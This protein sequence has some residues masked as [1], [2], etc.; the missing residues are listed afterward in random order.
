MILHVRR[1]YQEGK[2][3]EDKP[4][5]LFFRLEVSPEEAEWLDEYEDAWAFQWHG[6]VKRLSALL[7][8]ESSASFEMFA[9]RTCT[10]K[11]SR[12]PARIFWII[13]GRRSTSPATTRMRSSCRTRR[14]LPPNRKPRLPDLHSASN[15]LGSIGV[16]PPGELH[17]AGPGSTGLLGQRAGTR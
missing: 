7:N 17:N 12:T 14:D 16:A 11:N 10:S 9:Q 6:P 8:R 5:W 4:Y 2:Q 3:P 13:A 15:G 1:E